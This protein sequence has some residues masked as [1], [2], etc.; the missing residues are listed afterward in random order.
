VGVAVAKSASH[1]VSSTA[2]TAAKVEAAV[3]K[4]GAGAVD[5]IY[6]IGRQVD[7]AVAKDWAGH[8][9]LDLPNWTLAKNDEWVKGIVEQR[10][11]VYIGSPQT[12]KTLWD[13]ANNRQ[14][15][16]ARELQQLRD[17]GYI[18][19]GDYMLPP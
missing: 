12:Q 8:K 5:D 9:V 4:E 3:V 6:V 19:S 18:K 13:A 14:T 2:A 10:A 7:T 15:V 17:A 11:R 16:F 1:A